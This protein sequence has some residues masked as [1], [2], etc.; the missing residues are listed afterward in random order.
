MMSEL[1]CPNVLHIYKH[2]V[3]GSEPGWCGP[4]WMCIVPLVWD[5]NYPKTKLTAFQTLVYLE[6]VSFSPSPWSLFHLSHLSLICMPHP[7]LTQSCFFSEKWPLSF[8]LLLLC[9][10]PQS[11]TTSFPL[12]VVGIQVRASCM[13]WLGPVGMVFSG[14]T[15]SDKTWGSARMGGGEEV[16][17]LL[18]SVGADRAT[19]WCFPFALWEQGYEAVVESWTALVVMQLGFLLLFCNHCS[20]IWY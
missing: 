17:T 16:R 7:R 13:E 11:T 12:H 5:Y 2:L 19:T 9:F 15:W 18:V 8:L 3:G 14:D 6:S 1:K 4:A 10:S 20:W